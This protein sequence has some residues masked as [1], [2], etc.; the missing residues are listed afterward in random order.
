MLTS[1]RV[2]KPCC[3]SVWLP[4]CLPAAWCC[5]EQHAL[6][7]LS[8]ALRQEMALFRVSVSVLQP[9]YVQSEIFGK[10]P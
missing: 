1:W 8:D 10:V 2:L 3:P 6:E 4:A 5:G 7:A 9:A